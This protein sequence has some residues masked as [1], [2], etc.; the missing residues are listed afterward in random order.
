M[1]FLSRVDVAADVAG[2]KCVAMW[3][4]IYMPR[5]ARICVYACVCVCVRARGRVISEIN[6]HVISELAYILFQ[7]IC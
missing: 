7:D 2:A 3:P 6:V 4:C 5:G 1:I